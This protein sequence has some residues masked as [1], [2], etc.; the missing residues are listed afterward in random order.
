MQ[1]LSF[2]HFTGYRTK[3]QYIYNHGKK[4]QGRIFFWGNVLHF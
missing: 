1:L 2:F 4:F 3:Y